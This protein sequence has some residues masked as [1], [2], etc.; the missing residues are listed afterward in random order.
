MF[1]KELKIINNSPI[2]VQQICKNELKIIIFNN[3][4]KKQ[5]KKTLLLTLIQFA[6]L[7][8]LVSCKHC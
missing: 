1:E 7:M 3:E 4:E 2:V 6:L 5:M 8:I